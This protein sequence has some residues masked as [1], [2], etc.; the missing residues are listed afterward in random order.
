MLLPLTHTHISADASYYSKINK[1]EWYY[2]SNYRLTGKPLVETRFETLEKAIDVCIR[3]KKCRGVSHVGKKEFVLTGTTQQ[4]ANPGMRYWLKRGKSQVEIGYSWS[5]YPKYISISDQASSKVYSN[6]R[7]AAS[8]CLSNAKCKA[9]SFDGFGWTERTGLEIKEQGNGHVWM[10]SYQIKTY[11]GYYYQPLAGFKYGY[12]NDK[13][14]TGKFKALQACSIQTSCSGVTKES[15]TKYRLCAGSDLKKVSAY[16]LY[17]REGMIETTFDMFYAGYIWSAHSPYEFSDWLDDTEYTS[18]DAAANACSQSSMCSGFTYMSDKKYI[19]ARS[20]NKKKVPGRIAYV[21]GGKAKYNSGYIWEERFDHTL[22]GREGAQIGMSGAWQQVTPGKKMKQISVGSMGVWAVDKDQKIF[23]LVNGV[24]KQVPGSLHSISVGGTQVWGVNK[25]HVAYKYAG[26]NKWTL[27]GG[28]D[29]AFVDVSE[30]DNVWAVSRLN[31]VF[32]YTGSEFKF[33]P[34]VCKHITVGPAGVWCTKTNGEPFYREGTYGDLNTKGTG[35]TKIDGNVKWMGS[36]NGIMVAVNNGDSIYYRSGMSSVKPTGT[37]WVHVGGRLNNIDVHGKVVYGSNRG[38]DLYRCM[39][40]PDGQYR[41][42]LVTYENAMRQ[43]AGNQYCKGHF[44]R[45]NKYIET[46][47]TKLHRAG[48]QVA[49]VKRGKSSTYG[50]YLWIY[51]NNYIGE[52]YGATSYSSLNVAR[53]KCIATSGV[54]IE[55]L[56]V[57]INHK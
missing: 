42:H 51:K 52:S 5:T 6:R 28:E 15:A 53:A 8:A 14:Y 54:S 1:V 48:N 46:T 3:N 38:Q 50:G 35:W 26:N 29:L 19:L 22:Q 44:Y 40:K 12:L 16:T 23:R 27:M 32:R 31:N 39:L 10:P 41:P 21:K 45:G 7:G 55:I 9:V 30:N 37:H 11:G 36:G 57:F 25:K 49:Y 18:R 33:V 24:W 4:K 47:S 20:G 17:K 43:C 13:V 34:G 56:T 2:R